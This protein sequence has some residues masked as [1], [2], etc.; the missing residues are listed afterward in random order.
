MTYNVFGGTL[1]L[2][3][4]EMWLLE[5]SEVG[6]RRAIMLRQRQD[7]LASCSG[8]S[9]GAAD[10]GDVWNDFAANG[11]DSDLDDA[12]LPPTTN[13]RPPV[14]SIHQPA[15]PVVDTLCN[16]GQSTPPF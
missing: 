4:L 1:N 8:G 6:R 5:C 16:T 11:R 3:Q 12:P 15:P 13:C 9:D 2:A 10:L 7:S 14:S